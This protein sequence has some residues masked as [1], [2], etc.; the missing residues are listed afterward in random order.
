MSNSNI[1]K[2]WKDPGYRNTL[3]QAERDALP[4]NPAGSIEISDADLGKVAGGVARETF[5]TIACPSLACPTA[6]C[7]VCG[8]VVSDAC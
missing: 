1:I 4:A 8:P 5:T 3:S 7:T 6:W 2:A